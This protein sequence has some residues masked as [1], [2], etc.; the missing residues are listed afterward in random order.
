MKIIRLP[1]VLSLTGLSK[2]TVYSRIKE[3][4]FP[5]SFSLGGK[6]SGWLEG[7]I[8]ACNAFQSTGCSNKEL[9]GFIQMLVAGRHNS[10]ALMMGGK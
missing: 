2:S 6:A 1:E 7:E 5:P 9:K 10:D 8:L 4:V 3:G